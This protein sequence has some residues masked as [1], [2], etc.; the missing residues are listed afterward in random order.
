MSN[1]GFVYILTNA[2]MPDL[3]KVGCTERSPHERASELSKGTA[4]PYPFEVVCF[5]EVVNF[6]DAERELHRWLANFRISESREFFEGCLPHAVAWLW[7]H[8]ARFSFCDVP[9]QAFGRETILLREE[10]VGYF[11]GQPSFYQLPDPWMDE[12]GADT[13]PEPGKASLLRLVGRSGL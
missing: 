1:I 11:T 6:Q 2:Y 8:R 3:I 10:F 7:W 12:E 4:V 5:A 9:G 13:P